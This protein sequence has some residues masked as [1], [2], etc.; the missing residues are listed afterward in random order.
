MSA[1]LEPGS[2]ALGGARTFRA[3]LDRPEPDVAVLRAVGALSAA[4]EP[5]FSAPVREH[6]NAPLA[7]FVLDLSE[8]D[9][10]DTAAAVTMLEAVHRARSAGAVLRVVSSPAVDGLLARL[11]LADSF[12]YAASTGAAVAEFRAARA[13]DRGTLSA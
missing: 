6:L 8:V 5:D 4:A 10:L 9:D 1:L 11:D 7:L 2:G 12:T 13:G 3:E